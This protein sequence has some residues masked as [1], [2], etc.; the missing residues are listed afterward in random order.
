ML[1]LKIKIRPSHLKIKSL[2]LSL[3]QLK[4][5]NL[6]RNQTLANS[7]MKIKIMTQIK[8]RFRV[9]NLRLKYKYL[10]PSPASPQKYKL[11]S[12]HCILSW[13]MKFR[14]ENYILYLN[15][16]LLNLL[17]LPTPPPRTVWM[18]FEELCYV[19]REWC[20]SFSR[21]S[22]S[23]SSIVKFPK[24]VLWENDK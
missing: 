5:S 12:F 10:P 19:L 16:L 14:F 8:N 4:F 20:F 2:E 15:N 9:I 17:P 22:I 13:M 3:I 18:C 24:C 6:S 23:H 1:A 11:L 21:T 7:Y